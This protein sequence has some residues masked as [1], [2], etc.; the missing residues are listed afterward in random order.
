MNSAQ[1]LMKAF[2][3]NKY[4]G[5]RL[6]DLSACKVKAECNSSAFLEFPHQ[7]ETELHKIEQ[8][9]I[10]QIALE[11]DLAK[12]YCFYSELKADLEKMIMEL[13]DERYRF[14]IRHR[15][16]DGFSWKTITGLTNYSSRYLLK[17]HKCAL[18]EFDVVYRNYMKE[19]T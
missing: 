15:Y 9:V 11:N 3:Y 12:D 14:I 8:S 7:N 10:E 16:C 13:D 19:D 4:I 6:D 5:H 1:Y 2:R 17:L 18:E